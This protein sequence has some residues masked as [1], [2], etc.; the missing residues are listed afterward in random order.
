MTITTLPPY[1]M[2]T[3]T[4]HQNL[5]VQHS[6]HEG[7][8]VPCCV[9]K[10]LAVYVKADPADT[11]AFANFVYTGKIE[12][13][14]KPTIS[15]ADSTAEQYDMAMADYRVKLVDC[16]KLGREL[17]S[18]SFQDAVMD[19]LVNSFVGDVL[20]SAHYISEWGYDDTIT[21]PPLRRLAVDLAVHVPELNI[22]GSYEPEDRIYSAVFAEL[23]ELRDKVKAASARGETVAFE[24]PWKNPGC[25]YHEHGEKKPCYK[26][27]F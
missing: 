3:V 1:R 15:I 20:F 16:W 19:E 12:L 8:K 4:L 27:L 2:A 18:S 21:P 25:R 23:L 5:A 7:F 14:A 10:A 17:Q 11:D 9:V 6:T 13:E 26:T 22:L 24:E